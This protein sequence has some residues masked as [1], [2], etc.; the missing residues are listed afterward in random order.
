MA[1]AVA[2]LSLSSHF[3][4]AGMMEDAA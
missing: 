3:E 2:F 4:Q 1:G